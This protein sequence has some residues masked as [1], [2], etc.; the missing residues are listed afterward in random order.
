MKNQ[1]LG[2]LL[3]V[4]VLASS[5]GL[6]AAQFS[7]QV[8]PSSQILRVGDTLTLTMTIVIEG[9]PEK[10][11]AEPLSKLELPGFKTIATSPRHRKGTRDSI[12]FEERITIFK[13]VAEEQGEYTIP[14]FEIPYTYLPDDSQGSLSSSEVEI[15]VLADAGVMTGQKA[16]YIILVFLVVVL[17][18]VGGFLLWLKHV[19]S[20]R[21]A[22]DEKHNIDKKFSNWLIELDKHLASGKKDTFTEQAY[23]FVNE[24]IEDNYHIGLKG[25]KFEKRIALCREKQ[26]DPNLMEMLK[27]TYH[28]LEEMKFGGIVRESGELEGII[29][30]LRDLKQNFNMRL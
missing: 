14:A 10:Y 17:L 29:K 6:T 19:R 12:E 15:T 1:L 23:N 4:L 21:F 25:R 13:L 18:S 11:A 22:D 3:L 20:R 24:F 27:K 5:A 26:V 2:K 16:F 7:F 28:N 8:E 9:E 30:Q